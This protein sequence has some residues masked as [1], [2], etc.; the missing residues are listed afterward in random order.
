MKILFLMAIVFLISGCQHPN[1]ADLKIGMTI[2]DVQRLPGSNLLRIA[3]DTQT[4]T[5]RCETAAPL[6]DGPFNPDLYILTFDKS[7]NKLISFYKR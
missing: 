2:D 1:V 3:E 5:Y 6:V 7:S 4:V